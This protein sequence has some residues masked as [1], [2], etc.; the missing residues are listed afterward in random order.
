MSNWLTQSIRADIKK[1]NTCRTRSKAERVLGFEPLLLLTS[2]FHL[3]SPLRFRFPAFVVVVSLVFISFP[4]LL[5]RPFVLLSFSFVI[6]TSYPAFLIRI[7]LSSRHLR[8]GFVIVIVHHAS[9]HAGFILPLPFVHPY[10]S[11]TPHNVSSMRLIRRPRNWLF[12]TVL[13]SPDN[14]HQHP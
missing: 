14:A 5:S 1:Y 6:A 13:T 8:S 11:H 3:L 7:A 4:R 10:S 9:C 2:Y 12:F